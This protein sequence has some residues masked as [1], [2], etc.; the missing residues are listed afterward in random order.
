[1]AVDEDE[2]Y[3]YS[4]FLDVM[5]YMTTYS[6][7]DVEQLS[8]NADEIGKATEDMKSSEDT[9]LAKK[10]KVL[11]DATAE[12]AEAAKEQGVEG[13]ADVCDKCHSFSAAAEDI[14]IKGGI[15]PKS[16]DADKI[17][18]EMAESTKEDPKDPDPAPADPKD[19]K[20]ETKCDKS[21]SYLFQNTENRTFSTTTP[22]DN[23]EE[24]KIFGNVNGTGETKKSVNPYLFSKIN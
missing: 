11:A 24:T 4:D 13:A 9:E 20:T 19:P 16:V 1:M 23:K 18:S 7:D 17:F 3:T 8:K 6:D 10:V 2:N 21:Y 5:E 14:L 12:E 22:K 15:N